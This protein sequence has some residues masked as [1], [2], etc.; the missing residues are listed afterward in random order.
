MHDTLSHTYNSHYT[1]ERK[2]LSESEHSTPVVHRQPI[3]SQDQSEYNVFTTQKLKQGASLVSE[4][5][6]PLQSQQTMPF[7][8]R[9]SH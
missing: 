1:E 4:L 3:F 2:D 6:G 8:I 9:G 5:S 7:D